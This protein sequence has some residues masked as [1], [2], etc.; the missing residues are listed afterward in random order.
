MGL[1]HA[2]EC[3]PLTL[4]RPVPSERETEEGLSRTFEAS[5]KNENEQGYDST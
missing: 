1:S 3:S 2:D 4:E 5:K